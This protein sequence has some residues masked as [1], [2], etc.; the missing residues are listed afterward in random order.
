[1]RRVRDTKQGA[2]KAGLETLL[3]RKE[4]VGGTCG[5]RGRVVLVSLPAP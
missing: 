2:K 5:V 1:M 4:Q 3:H